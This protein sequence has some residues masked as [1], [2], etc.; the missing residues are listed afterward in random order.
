MAIS[1]IA[2]VFRQDL[3]P[4]QK[5]VLLALAD[6][7]NDDDGGCWFLLKTLSAKTG[8]SERSLRYQFDALEAA[9]Y[10]SRKRRFGRSSLFFLSL[11]KLGMGAGGDPAKVAG[12]PK[13]DP[14]MVA[15]SSG[16]GCRINR[17]GLPDHPAKVA[18]ISGSYPS[19]YPSLNPPE[20]GRAKNAL[21]GSRNPEAG[22]RSPEGL[23]RGGAGAPDPEP[24]YPP[25]HRRRM[26]QLLR[27]SVRG[28]A[29]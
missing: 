3:P 27:E 22:T 20:A 26:L 7:A 21:P 18:T 10:L 29:S 19:S 16:N 15:G 6:S 14:A 28:I 2:A 25:E 4:T 8:C 13:A 11:D 23:A 5:L 24:E 1:L 9:G 12:S 17:Q